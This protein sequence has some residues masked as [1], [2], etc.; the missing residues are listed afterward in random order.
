MTETQIGP[1]G[2]G[3]AIA[4]DAIVPEDIKD[5]I[6]RFM[7]DG[8]T[9]PVKLY[10]PDEAAEILREVRV[11]SQDTSRSV[12]KNSMNYDR[13]LDIPELSRH[14]THPTILSTT[15]RYGHG[16]TRRPC[17]VFPTRS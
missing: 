8:F 15:R 5:G 17:S 3:A 6:T 14:V 16:A 9:G 4:D 11:K 2:S 10:E 1:V 12:F 13:H 7:R